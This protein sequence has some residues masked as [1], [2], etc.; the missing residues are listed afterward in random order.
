MSTTRKPG[1]AKTLRY[2]KSSSFY[3]D[4]KRDFFLE[5]RQLLQKAGEQNRLYASQPPRQ[6]CK[7]CQHAMPKAPDFRSHGV[8]YGF[9]PGCGHL[10]GWFEE[11]PAFVESLYVAA[12]GRDYATSYIDSD[13]AKR[14]LDIYLPKVDFM[15]SALSSGTRRLLDVGCGSGYFV[16]ACQQRGLDAEGIDVSREMVAFGNQQI[17]GRSGKTPLRHTSEAEFFE[18]VVEA[19][20]DVIAA[21]GV[22]EHLREPARFFEAFRKSQARYLFYSV[23]M[24]SLSVILENLFA[25]VFP[26]QLSGGHTHLFTEESIVKLHHLLA[27][28]PLAE[29]RFGTDA[30][31]LYRSLLASLQEQAVSEGL[32]ARFAK[33]FAATIDPIQAALDRNHFCSELH[34]VAEK[35]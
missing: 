27:V 18:R 5:N 30:M 21:I 8:P 9:C 1:T 13:F 32:V 31:D 15:L 10:N 6:R 29:W 16:L 14:T 3:L 34:C 35:T 28:A 17:G 26:R 7:L 23:P 20:A 4:T 11:T 2:T 22:I 25:Q 33:G 12:G 24:F 19:E